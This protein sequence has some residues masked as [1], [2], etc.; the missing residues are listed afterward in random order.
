MRT[1]MNSLLVYFTRQRRRHFGSVFARVVERYPPDSAF[2]ER[3]ADHPKPALPGVCTNSGHAGSS[4][5][6]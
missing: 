3:E 1:I 5:S 2:C 4:W 6:C